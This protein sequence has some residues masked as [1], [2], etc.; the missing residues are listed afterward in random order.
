[1]GRYLKIAY[2]RYLKI[3]MRIREEIPGDTPIKI[4]QDICVLE[5]YKIIKDTIITNVIRKPKI[6]EG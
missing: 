2:M 1:M 3:L 4:P 5:R 6:L